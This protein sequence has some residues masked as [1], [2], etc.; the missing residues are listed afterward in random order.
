MLIESYPPFLSS[1]AGEG[2]REKIPKDFTPDPSEKIRLISIRISSNGISRANE[3]FPRSSRRFSLF[4]FEQQQAIPLKREGER[5]RERERTAIINI[6]KVIKLA[7]WSTTTTTTIFERERKR[8]RCIAIRRI[9]RFRGNLHA[10]GKTSRPILAP[11]SSLNSITTRRVTLPPL[12]SSPSFSTIISIT[13]AVA[14]QVAS[15]FTGN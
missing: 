1:F 9:L 5:E 15:M 3:I 14:S 2:E 12:P 11:L 4:Y 10:F 6:R 8:V 13:K 7:R